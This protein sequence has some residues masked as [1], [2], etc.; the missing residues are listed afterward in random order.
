MRYELRTLSVRL[1]KAFR[2]TRDVEHNTLNTQYP[3]LISCT[4]NK[5]ASLINEAES[6]R[7]KA[8]KASDGSANWQ[9][10]QPGLKR[11]EDGCNAEEGGDL[12][13]RLL[14]MVG[15]SSSRFISPYLTPG[16]L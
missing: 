13:L 14:D 5:R 3:Q 8:R 10:N 16:K 9:Q 1:R 11:N 6:A 2:N 15:L 12:G 4:Q 7:S